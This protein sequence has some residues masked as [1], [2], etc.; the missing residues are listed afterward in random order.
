M[1][2]P[3]SHRVIHNFLRIPFFS[4]AAPEGLQQQGV[5]EIDRDTDLEPSAILQTG[6]E[7]LAG[8]LPDY[9]NQTFHILMSVLIRLHGQTPE[10]VEAQQIL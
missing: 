2:T 5:E 4:C 9:G 10:V 7:E 1:C 8:F 6:P 3:R